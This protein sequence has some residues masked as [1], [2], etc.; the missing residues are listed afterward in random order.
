MKFMQRILAYCENNMK[1]VTTPCL[2]GAETL[3]G[4]SIPQSKGK[5][6][7]LQARLWPRGWVDV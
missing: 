4:E 3:W 2:Q 1:H 7:P 5:M 6:F